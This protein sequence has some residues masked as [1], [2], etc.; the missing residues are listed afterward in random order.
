MNSP[1]TVLHFHIDILLQQ[2]LT[3]EQ[4]KARLMQNLD[5]DI[6]EEEQGYFSRSASRS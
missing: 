2:K 1:S 5:R 6:E 3:F 4:E